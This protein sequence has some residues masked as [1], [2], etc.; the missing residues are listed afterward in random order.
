MPEVALKRAEGAGASLGPL[1]RFVSALL[2]GQELP[3][4]PSSSGWAKGGEMNGRPGPAR[5]G[6]LAH[7]SIAWSCRAA[8][9]WCP[10]Q[11]PVEGPRRRWKV[12][13]SRR[14]DD[15]GVWIRRGGVDGD[16]DAHVGAAA[17]EVGREGKPTAGPV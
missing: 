10:R 4:G 14:T 3:H 9:S 16:A 7:E 12:A 11:G 15:V 8:R 5:L 2:P 6:D 13:R 17:A 1:R